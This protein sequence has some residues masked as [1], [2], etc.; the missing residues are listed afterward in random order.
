MKTIEVCPSTLR[1]GYVTYSPKAV[2]EL[3]DG[4]V[5]SPFIDIDFENEFRRNS[6]P[7]LITGGFVW[8]VKANRPLI[9]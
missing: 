2:K 6:L 7:S 4:V 5:V 3:F 8:H 9:S 1:P